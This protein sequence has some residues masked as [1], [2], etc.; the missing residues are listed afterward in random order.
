MTVAGSRDVTGAT[1]LAPGAAS[2][3]EPRSHD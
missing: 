3:Y 1:G 2:L